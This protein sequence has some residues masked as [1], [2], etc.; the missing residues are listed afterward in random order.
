MLLA[1]DTH[2]VSGQT[3]TAGVLFDEWSAVAPAREVVQTTA[4]PPPA[5]VPGRLYVRELP[6]I[7]ALLGSLEHAPDVIVVDAYVWLDLAGTPGLG[8]HLYEALERQTPVVG[9]AKNP[10]AGSAHAV[11][12]VRGTSRRP[13]YVTAAGVDPAVAAGWISAMHGAHRIPALL[14]RADQLCRAAVR[15]E[16]A[17]QLP[18]AK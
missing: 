15:R 7:V 1:T 8:A 18:K 14:A 11:A 9:V 17:A 3:A 6:G 16:R 2:Y 5:Y 10:F 12:I 4:E 13:L